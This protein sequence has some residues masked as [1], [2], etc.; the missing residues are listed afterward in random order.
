MWESTQHAVLAET[1]FN[2]SSYDHNL[3]N[4]HI[5]NF[6]RKQYFGLFSLHFFFFSKR[7]ICVVNFMTTHCH[8]Y[9]YCRATDDCEMGT[10]K[11]TDLTRSPRMEIRQNLHMQPKQPFQHQQRALSIRTSFSSSTLPVS[12]KHR[13]KFINLRDSVKKSPTKST[14]KVKAASGWVS[15]GSCSNCSLEKV[16]IALGIYRCALLMQTIESM[17]HFFLS[18]VLSLLFLETLSLNFLL[19]FITRNQSS[20]N[21]IWAGKEILLLSVFPL[22]LLQSIQCEFF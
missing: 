20:N 18:V 12:S 17:L 19:Y 4:N 2:V 8:D 3:E 22:R 7:T 6:L 10:L 16:C 13:G 21:W 15:D 1:A 14:A 5:F 11:L 9:K